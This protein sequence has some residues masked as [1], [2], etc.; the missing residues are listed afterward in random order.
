VFEKE[1]CTYTVEKFPLAKPTTSHCIL[2]DDL[3]PSDHP[4]SRGVGTAGVGTAGVGTGD[5]TGSQYNDGLN[6]AVGSAA[7][8]TDLEIFAD[9]FS[10]DAS[11]NVSSNKLSNNVFDP[12]TIDIPGI[13]G[14]KEVM[15][16]F[17]HLLLYQFSELGGLCPQ[18]F[19]DSFV[20]HLRRCSPFTFELPDDLTL[21]AKEK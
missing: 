16:V 18:R 15:S 20:K 12:E 10:Q 3:A 5:R 4:T 17:W 6:N 13:R 14:S 11:E 9:N 19:G 7:N 21:Q 8:L 2:S 1:Y